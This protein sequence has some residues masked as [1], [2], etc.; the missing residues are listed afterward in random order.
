MCGRF[1][2]KHALA[3]HVGQPLGEDT[4]REAGTDH[5]GVEAGVAGNGTTKRG[6][7]RSAVLLQEVCGSVVLC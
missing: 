5:Q 6:I 1:D 7:D 2:N 3:E 4:S